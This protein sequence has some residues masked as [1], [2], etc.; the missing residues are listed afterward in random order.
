MNDPIKSMARG[1][2]GGALATVPM[3]VVMLAG[4]RWLSRVQRDALPPAR[5]T[6]EAMKS[7]DLHDDFTHEQRLVLA[8]AAHFGYGATMGAIHGQLASPRSAAGA[9]VSGIAFGLGVWSASYLGLMPALGLYRHAAQEPVQ[10]NALMIAAHVVWGASLGLALHA[11]NRTAV[12][13]R[14]SSRR[15]GRRVR[16][17]L[18]QP[19]G[20]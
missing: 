17:R 3:S 1:A 19:A 6:S 15:F 14:Q 2:L 20:E 13:P 16:H 8:A 11:F 7:A 9:A 18:R 12:K 5:I 4:K 10:R